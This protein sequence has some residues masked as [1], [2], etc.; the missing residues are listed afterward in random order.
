MNRFL[1]AIGVCLLVASVAEGQQPPTE[2]PPVN[3]EPYSANGFLELRPVMIWQ[4]MDAAL[5]RLRSFT[6]PTPDARTMQLNSRVQFD[7]AYRR[8]WFSAQ[9]RAVADA[10]YATRSGAATRRPTK[11]FFL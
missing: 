8:G 7:A 9:T 11:R 1:W 5:F 2:I 4:D 3:R 10:A 6:D